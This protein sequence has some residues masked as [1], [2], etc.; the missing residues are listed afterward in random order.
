MTSAEL[1]VTS[2]EEK[3]LTELLLVW[4]TFIAVSISYRC[5]LYPKNEISSTRPVYYQPAAVY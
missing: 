2:D 3:P 1:Q 4:F 5:D